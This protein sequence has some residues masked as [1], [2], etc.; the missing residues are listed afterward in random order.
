VTA[1]AGSELDRPRDLRE[2][3]RDSVA[4]LAR[5]P[6]AF[7]AVGLV[8]AVP[9][10][11]VVSGVGL[12]QLTA[13]YDERTRPVELVV[14]TVA[15]YVLTTPLIT[16]ACA[17]LVTGAA[18]TPGRAAIRA[19]ETS[20]PLI[21]AAIVAA[22]G[23]AVGLFFLIL[24]GLYLLVRWFLYPQ[25]VALEDRRGTQPLRRSGELTEGR[26]FRSAGVIVLANLVALLPTAALAL[27]F[28]A[29]ALST[30]REL[31]FLA[32]QTLAQAI[33]VPIVAVIATVLFFDLR[34]RRAQPFG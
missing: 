4:L 27:P 9:V 24:P 20:T 21:L 7:L 5:R 22:I 30:D 13:P 17:L 2:L 3:L 25:A 6:L 15:R 32:G 10:E 34:A 16:A 26:W 31:P 11:L 19:V 1:G 33:G 18:P 14:P 29:L 8:F 23:V 12:E 28:Q